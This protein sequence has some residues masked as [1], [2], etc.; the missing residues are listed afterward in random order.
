MAVGTLSQVLV[1]R[2]GDAEY[3]VPIES[4]NG[5]D[6]HL[7][8]DQ[9]TAVPDAPPWLLG[10]LNLRGLVVP[11]VDL[12]LRLGLPTRSPDL[13][14]PI[15]VITS[16]G[17]PLGL[18]ADTVVEVLA[19]GPEDRLAPDEAV[20]LAH[21]IDSVLRVGRRLLLALA[22]DRLATDLPAAS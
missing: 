2:A 3:A 1:L 6:R 9:L 10:M 11:V 8:Y 18:V 21:P 14:T 4:V 17:R 16:R 7:L 22:P 20:G 19:V 13:S 15:V 12:R 5:P